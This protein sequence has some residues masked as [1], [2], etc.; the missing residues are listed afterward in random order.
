MAYADEFAQRQQ[1]HLSLAAYRTTVC[2]GLVITALL[3]LGV[4]GI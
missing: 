4:T 2:V 1:Q 3:Q